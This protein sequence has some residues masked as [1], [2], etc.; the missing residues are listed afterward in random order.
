[1]GQTLRRR[2]LA[3]GRRVAE[4][5]VPANIFAAVAALPMMRGGENP[6]AALYVVVDALD[7][8][9][10]RGD[11]WLPRSP[12][13]R[14]ANQNLSRSTHTH[15]EHRMNGKGRTTSGQQFVVDFGNG[16]EFR[17]FAHVT[18]V[19]MNDAGVIYYFS[20]SMRLIASLMA[21][22]SAFRVSSC[23]VSDLRTRLMPLRAAV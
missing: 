10:I 20:S 13:I 5:A 18:P 9:C 15:K 22:T 21:G 16:S 2:L 1:M 8:P 3:V 11:H 14:S 19:A 17:S 4:R 12:G 23:L 7:W 6:R